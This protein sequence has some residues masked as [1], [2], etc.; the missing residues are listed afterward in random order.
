MPTKWYQARITDI[1]D[2][3]IKTKRFFIKIDQKEIFDFTP[4]QF[5]T[6]DLPI[7]DKRR[8]RW[9]SYSIANLPNEKNILEMCIVHLD[10]GKASDWFFNQAQIGDTI[11][12]KGPD[13]GFVLPIKNNKNLVY[14]CTGTGVAPFR[15][16]IKHLETN[17]LENRN[18][19]LIFGTRFF[20]GV[21]YR[22]EWDEM[23]EKYVGFHVSYALSRE[24]KIG[25]THGYVHN[26]YLEEY[27]GKNMEDYLFYICGWSNMIDE[28]VANLLTKLNVPKENIKY[29]LYG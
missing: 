11:K 22:K 10:G 15:S 23:V 24:N 18:V 29:E 16:M 25:F 20:D 27:H 26:I 13:G 1:R 6:L 28:A 3:G 2:I 21:L 14:I 7:G 17:D 9:R 19:H 12:F 8:D 5:I 4:G